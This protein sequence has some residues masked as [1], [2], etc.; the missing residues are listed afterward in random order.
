VV[1]SARAALAEA[2]KENKYEETID[3]YNNL[4]GQTDGILALGDNYPDLKANDAYLRLLEEFKNS[5][6]V[7]NAMRKNY[8]Q[9]VDTYNESLQRLPFGLVAYGLQFTKI[10]PKVTAD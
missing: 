6:N 10:E 4:S 8:V 7:T 2:L 9:A 3:A 1:T 5:V